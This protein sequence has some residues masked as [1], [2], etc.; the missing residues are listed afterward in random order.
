MT[1]HC[2]VSLSQCAKYGVVWGSFLFL[3]PPFRPLPV[4]CLF[5][6]SSF[7]FLPFPCPKIQ[8][9]I[10]LLRCNRISCVTVVKIGVWWQWESAEVIDKICCMWQPHRQ[11]FLS[12]KYSNLQ[13]KNHCKNERFLWDP[14]YVPKRYKFAR[15]LEFFW[16]FWPHDPPSFRTLVCHEFCARF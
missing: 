13:N 7:P 11:T 16:G 8:L 9:R 6:I 15:S 10:L 12:Q 3:S 5:S 2:Y 4:Y 1:A 14:F